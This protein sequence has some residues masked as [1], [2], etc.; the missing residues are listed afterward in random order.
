[1]NN[2]KVFGKER[3]ARVEAAK[4]LVDGFNALPDKSTEALE[5]LVAVMKGKNA[6]EIKATLG[7]TVDSES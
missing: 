1:M 5:R 3:N 2:S 4:A 7:G 6:N